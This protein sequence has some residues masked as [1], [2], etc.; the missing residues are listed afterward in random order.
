MHTRL[1]TSIAEMRSYSREVRARGKSLA[2]VP[3][4]GALHDGHLSMVRRAKHQCD[5]V[6]VSIFV[7]PTQFTPGEDFTR[8]PRDLEKDSE[9]LRSL[10]VDAIFVPSAEEVYPPDFDTFI[11]P[12]KLAAPLEGAARPGHFRGVSTIVLKLFNIVHPDLAYF[13]QKDFQQV[14]L[15][16][17]LVEDLNLDVRLVI[18]PIVRDAD[19]V[20][21]SS[22]NVYLAPEARRAARILR[23][24]LLEAEML[25]HAG[26]GDPE[27]LLKEM[28]RMLATEPMVQLEYLAIIDPGRFEA[29]ERVT[30]GSRCPDRRLRWRRPSDRQPCLWSPRFQSRSVAAIGFH[31]AAG[32]ADGSAHSGH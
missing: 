19:G 6:A 26:E 29:A 32:H 13:G 14:Q 7:N 24:C 30:A 11:Q 12:G 31:F 1:L 4:M 28:R 2:L 20:A 8:Y 27:I 15:I 22:R 25:V 21:L 17:K 18:C 3:T 9:L 23:R 16:R 5:V 10:N